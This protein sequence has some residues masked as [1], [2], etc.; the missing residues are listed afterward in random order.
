MCDTFS[1]YVFYPQMCFSCA[2]AIPWLVAYA[3]TSHIGCCLQMCHGT[4]VRKM[5]LFCTIRSTPMWDIFTAL[6][7]MTSGS[8]R[9]LPKS[10]EV[11]VYMYVCT[12]IHYMYDVG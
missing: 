6:H 11:H 1:L 4:C 9:L 3:Y 2:V 10:V 8:Y 12:F 7:V 5:G